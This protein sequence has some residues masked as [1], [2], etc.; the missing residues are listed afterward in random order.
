M[1]RAECALRIR[2]IVLGLS[3]SRGYWKKHGN[4][5]VRHIDGDG[6]EARLC[7]P[8]NP[9]S[10]WRRYAVYAETS[11]DIEI[12]PYR[13]CVWLRGS[14]KIL[15]LEWSA[16]RLQIG[17]FRRG[18]WESRLFGLEPYSGKPTHIY[19]DGSIRRW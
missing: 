19:G 16:T 4:C 10:A 8:F 13:L 12:Y 2:D 3:A 6:W 18:E 5:Y 9:D 17:T 7:T 11:G 14:G 1:T 15:T